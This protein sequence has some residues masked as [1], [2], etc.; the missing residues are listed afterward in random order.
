MH[1]VAEQGKNTTHFLFFAFILSIEEL[2]NQNKKYCHE[3]VHKRFLATGPQMKGNNI[4]SES[5]KHGHK[6]DG[7]QIG[8]GLFAK[9]NTLNVVVL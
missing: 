2:Y 7:T 8:N 5:N 3:T 9:E 6:A 1:Q 4:A